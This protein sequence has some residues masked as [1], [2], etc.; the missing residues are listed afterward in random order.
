MTSKYVKRWINLCHTK[1]LNS[2]K[3]TLCS[4]TM[5]N[6]NPKIVSW[7]R[8][9]S[10]C[11]RQ[12]SK[13]AS[14]ASKKSAF[15]TQISLVCSRHINQSDSSQ[16]ALIR[17]CKQ[18]HLQL[19]FNQAQ[20]F[21]TKH[22]TTPFKT[23]YSLAFGIVTS[24]QIICSIQPTGDQTIFLDIEPAVADTI[25]QTS[26]TC[27]VGSYMEIYAC[28]LISIRFQV[29]SVV[30]NSSLCITSPHSVISCR[31]SVILSVKSPSFLLYVVWNF[32]EKVGR[33][34][35]SVKLSQHHPKKQF[36]T[37]QIMKYPHND[38]LWNPC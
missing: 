13:V 28:K 9:W 30:L 37:A 1:T 3:L 36:N 6:G 20:A 4:A 12:Q 29:F 8:L 7:L 24:A 15:S 17:L 32:G 10:G 38:Y 25:Q 19:P 34:R 22:W 35:L 14:E 23:I 31:I 21:S 2:S 16:I 18:K 11:T 27:N 26:N 5:S 33:V